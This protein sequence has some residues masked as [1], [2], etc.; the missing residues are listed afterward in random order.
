MPLS[1]RNL[2]RACMAQVSLLF[3]GCLSE[4]SSTPTRTDDEWGDESYTLELWLEQVTLSKSERSSADPIVFDNLSEEK[5]EIFRVA[6]EDG[7]YTQQ[8]GNESAALEDL[9]YT[10]EQRAGEDM[11]VYLKKDDGYHA[12]GFVEG[13]HII[14]DP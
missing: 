2:I 4:N 12:V 3:I 11:T 1:R 9:R 10:I 6:I 14:A 13:D 7:K 8:I 5:Q